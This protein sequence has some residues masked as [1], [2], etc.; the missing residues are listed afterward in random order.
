MSD[1]FS[2]AEEPSS[3]NFNQTI[4]LIKDWFRYLKRRWLTILLLV[5]IGGGIG[6][7]IALFTPATYN[8]KLSFILEEGKSSAGG[9]SALAGQF[10]FDF[11][12]TSGSSLLSGENI[13]GLL[14][15]RKFTRAVLLTSYD[16]SSFS[17]ADRY[18]DIYELRDEW[19]ENKRINT[20]VYFPTT[21]KDLSRIQDSLLQIIE[22]RVLS[23]HL[24]VERPDKKM[25]FFTVGMTTKDEMLSKLFTERVVEDVVEF[26]IEA[27]TRRLRANVT[28][29]Q[30]KSDSIYA[31]LNNKTYTAAAAQSTLLDI[32]PAYQTATVAA[33]VSGRNKLMIGTIYAEIV[34]N[35]EIQKI[36]LSQET[37]V[38]Q[39]VDNIQLPLTMQRK[40]KFMY[41]I[42]GG[43]LSGIIAVG[44][45]ILIR[46]LK[47]SNNSLNNKPS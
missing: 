10:G 7:T 17:L 43:I 27:K 47:S 2:V 5:I 36:N 31:L 33:E 38:I 46:Y 21:G 23:D 45:L 40:S 14:K 13:V 41:L 1:I 20:K 30:N 29:L 28:R 34:K 39:V 11:G 26:Y 32:N 4:G 19:E 42:I 37:P 24:F 6:F 16:K 15:S 35:L 44:L 8:A 25:S 9:L 18:A 12:S 3:F 22:I